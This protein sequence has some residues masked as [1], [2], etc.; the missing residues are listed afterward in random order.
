MEYIKSDF[1]IKPVDTSIKKTSGFMGWTWLMTQSGVSVTLQMLYK[2]KTSKVFEKPKPGEGRAADL[3]E[4]DPFA[5]QMV[6]WCPQS[7]IFCVVGISAHIILYRFSKYD[8]N[9]QI[10]VSEHLKALKGNVSW[11]FGAWIVFCQLLLWRLQ[12]LCSWPMWSNLN[13]IH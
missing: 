3:V 12:W 11:R 13:S 10:V 5:V 9:T 4:E 2:L 8:A 1:N 7:R 6:S